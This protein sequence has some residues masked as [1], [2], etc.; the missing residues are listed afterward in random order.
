MSLSA[1]QIASDYEEVF[2]RRAETIAIRRYTGQ[3]GS[4]TSVDTICRAVVTGFAPHELVGSVVQG[5]RRLI[6]LIDAAVTA[7][8][9]ITVNDKAVIRSRECAI[10][11]ADDSTRRY[12]GT[13]IALELVVRG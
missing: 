9:P 12:A 2:A 5:D 13:L 10:Q 6:V 4:R 3:G 8:L 11:A 7:I 1:A